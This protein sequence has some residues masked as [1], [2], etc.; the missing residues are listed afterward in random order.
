MSERMA[1][2]IMLIFWIGIPLSYVY[3]HRGLE[4]LVK[5]VL[6]SIAVIMLSSAALWYIQRDDFKR[7]R[8]KK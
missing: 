1:T 8:G 7:Y 4:H 3:Q 2:A 5:S 6:G